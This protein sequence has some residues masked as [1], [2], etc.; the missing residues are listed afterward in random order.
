MAPWQ[1]DAPPWRD[2]EFW[3]D[4]DDEDLPDDWCEIEGILPTDDPFAMF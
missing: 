4:V 3:L 1:D 2:D